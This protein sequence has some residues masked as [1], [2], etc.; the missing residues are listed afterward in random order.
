MGTGKPF[1]H[2]TRLS[3]LDPALKDSS[4]KARDFLMNGMNL[5]EDEAFSLITVGTDFAIT[6]VV[7]GN[8]GVHGIIPKGIFAEENVKPMP[9]AS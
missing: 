3:S 9:A 7:D 2:P 5:T 6:Q 4:A 1:A 8:W